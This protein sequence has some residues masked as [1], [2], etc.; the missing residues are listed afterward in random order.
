MRIEMVNNGKRIHLTDFN[1]LEICYQ[2]HFC[3]IDRSPLV[4]DIIQ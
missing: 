2:V 1:D 4:F 3:S